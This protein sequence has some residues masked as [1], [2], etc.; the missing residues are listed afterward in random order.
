MIASGEFSKL[1]SDP[2]F[3]KVL[4]NKDGIYWEIF[5][6]LDFVNGEF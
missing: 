1:A 5:L 6:N 4:D 3:V 2:D